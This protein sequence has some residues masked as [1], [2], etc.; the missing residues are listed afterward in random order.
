MEE[1]RGADREPPA[2]YVGCCGA[3]CGTCRA[4]S[5]GACRGC[6]LGYEHGERDLARARCAVK[7]CCFR[8]RGLETCA[9]CPDYSGC[10]T[11]DGFLGKRG[12][13]YG[14]YR[15]S[16]EFIRENGY[17]RFLANAAGWKGAYGRLETAAD[18]SDESPA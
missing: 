6:R 8:D 17:D 10:G 11:I 1:S 12:Y 18:R 15:A 9:D 2:R 13:K 7:A 16:L 5:D 3:Y 14:R 4:W